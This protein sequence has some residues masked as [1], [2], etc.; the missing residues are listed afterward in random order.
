MLVR[1][2]LSTEEES[3]F[4]RSPWRQDD[5]SIR[6]RCNR[7]Q[8]APAMMDY[9]HTSRASFQFQG[10]SPLTVRSRPRR[11]EAGIWKEQLAGALH[12]GAKA[13]ACESYRG[14]FRRQAASHQHRPHEDR[15]SLELELEFLGCSFDRSLLGDRL[16][17][18]FGLDLQLERTSACNGLPIKAPVTTFAQ[19][20]RRVQNR[21]RA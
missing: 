17:I 16:Q 3:A 11:L 2:R 14:A 1:C 6:C 21:V 8:G 12:H 4:D 5:R 18:T 20:T 7:Q 10:E 9:R 19:K 15:S 13:S